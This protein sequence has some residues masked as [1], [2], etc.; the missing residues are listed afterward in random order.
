MSTAE[1]K[2]ACH[3]LDVVLT[4]LEMV[5]TDDLDF[6]HILRRLP[7]QEVDFLE[8]LLLVMR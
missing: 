6:A 8:E 7:L 5:A 1:H 2:A 4:L 3:I